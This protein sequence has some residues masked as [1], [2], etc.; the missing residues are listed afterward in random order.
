[1]RSFKKANRKLFTGIS[2]EI[3]RKI[4]ISFSKGLFRVR[5]S[6]IEGTKAR[7]EEK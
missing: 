4:F 1:L 3:Y 7:N 6:E 5:I 2:L